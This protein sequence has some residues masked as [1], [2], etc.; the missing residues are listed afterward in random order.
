MEVISQGKTPFG[1]ETTNLGYVNPVLAVHLEVGILP[2]LERNPR[3]S[4]AASLEEQFVS[5]DSPDP[6]RET[7]PWFYHGI[8]SIRT[9]R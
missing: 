4:C 3:W 8:W 2:L 6:E 1:A 7:I 9:I 5:W